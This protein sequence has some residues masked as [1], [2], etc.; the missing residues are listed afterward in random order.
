MARKKF[1][2]EEMRILRASPYVLD[3]STSI[4]HFSAEFKEKFWISLQAGK[5]PVEIVA[6]HGIDPK[7]LGETRISGLKTM[8]RNEARAGN[9]FR[10]LKTYQQKINGFMSD[11][12]K[13]RCLEQ[14]LAYKEQEIE[15]LKKIVSLGKV[16]RSI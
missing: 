8:I 11:D 3:V 2:E 16:E 7:M 4:V 9:G 10:D 5:Q 14:Q 15:F 13:I 12:A 1:T 6:E